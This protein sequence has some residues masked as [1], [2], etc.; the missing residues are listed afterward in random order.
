MK[1]FPLVLNTALLTILSL[2]VLLGPVVSHR[3]K[4]LLLPSYSSVPREKKTRAIRDI[5]DKII[6]WSDLDEGSRNR[7]FM[8]N[9]KCDFLSHSLQLWQR[10]KLVESYKYIIIFFASFFKKLS[11][12]LP[13]NISRMHAERNFPYKYKWLTQTYSLRLSKRNLQFIMKADKNVQRLNL[14]TKKACRAQ[15]IKLPKIIWNLKTRLASK[16]EKHYMK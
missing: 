16:W 14:V 15:K 11:R 12:S 2:V 6:T 3:F 7:D 5:G 10:T 8:V 4:N 13:N 1:I 9:L